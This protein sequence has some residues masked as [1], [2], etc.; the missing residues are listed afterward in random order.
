VITPSTS[1]LYEANYGKLIREIKADVLKW[2]ILPLSLVGRIETVRMNILP[3]LLFLFN[4]LPVKVPM[5]AFGNLDNLILRFVWQN[6]KARVRLKTL[7]LPKQ[8]GGLNLPN[9]KYY[10]WAA[11][12]RTLKAWMTNDIETGW[13]DIEQNSFPSVPLGALPFMSPASWKKL[14][15]DNEW[16][17]FTVK[18]WMVIRKQLSILNS[19]SRALKIAVMPEFPP[20]KI[21]KG[22]RTWAEKGLI[23]V[24]QL[25]VGETLKS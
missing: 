21:D 7:L 18:T 16:I 9:I 25:F 11:Q 15:I 22:F 3:R 5:A 17:K 14:K 4:S 6:K 23:T 12:M 8:K 19:L 24:D 20:G 2:E 10:Y 1:K 13:V